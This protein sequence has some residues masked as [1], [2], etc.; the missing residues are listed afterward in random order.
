MSIAELSRTREAWDRIAP[1]YDHFVTPTD[2]WSLP[3][4]A[5]QAAGLKPDMHVLDVASGSGALSLPAA[6]MGARVLAVD[7]SPAMVERL[8]A[9]ARDEG[10][11]NVEARVMDGHHLELDDRSF[12]LAASQFGVMLFP[13]L[14]RALGEMVRVVRPGGRVLMVAYGPPAEVGFLGLFLTAMKQAVP[15]FEGLP[16]DPPPLPFQVS[17]PEILRKRMLEA[18]LREVNIETTT[19]RL[20]FASGAEAWNWITNSNP[21]PAGIVGGLEPDTRERVR[22]ELGALVRKRAGGGAAARVEAAVHIA[23]G[24]R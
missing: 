10:L 4:R 1:G 19:E 6:R 9:R 15:D 11:E 18:G 16:S 20:D 13:D 14:P 23:V 24:S 8:R 17:D 12:D 2:D 7:L 5:L 3:V 22:S 21:I